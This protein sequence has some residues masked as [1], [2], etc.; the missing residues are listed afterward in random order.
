MLPSTAFG[1][2]EGL[3][4]IYLPPTDQT[5]VSKPAPPDMASDTSFPATTDIALDD[6]PDRNDDD[7]SNTSSTPKDKQD[8]TRQTPLRLWRPEQLQSSESESD[9]TAEENRKPPYKRAT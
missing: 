1:S 2:I 7:D 3:F 6:T 4:D 8:S 9:L 5:L